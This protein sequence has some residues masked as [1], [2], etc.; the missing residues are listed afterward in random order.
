[1]SKVVIE[2]IKITLFLPIT[3]CVDLDNYKDREYS[4]L[5]RIDAGPCK[6]NNYQFR[7]FWT[8]KGVL[9]LTKGFKVNWLRT[10]YDHRLETFFR[11]KI[12]EYEQLITVSD[13]EKND[14]I[15]DNKDSITVGYFDTTKIRTQ[16][17]SAGM[18]NYQPLGF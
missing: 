12:S 11:E 13:K 2:T 15:G 17:I 18:A 3:F 8:T 7:V 6:S 5:G 10:L 16:K 4:L 1:M 9:N 14:V